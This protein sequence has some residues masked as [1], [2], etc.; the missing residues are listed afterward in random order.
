M[1]I[2]HQIRGHH[3]I[4]VVVGV[5][6]DKTRLQGS[7][8]KFDPFGLGTDQRFDLIGRAHGDDLSLTGGHGL[9]SVASIVSI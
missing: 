9:V 6:I 8:R 3:T 7:A 1:A 4:H 5:G 2:H